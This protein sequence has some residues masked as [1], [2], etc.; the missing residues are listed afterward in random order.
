IWIHHVR[1]ASG[2]DRRPARAVWADQSRRSCPIC[3]V[4]PGGTITRLA[5]LLECARGKRTPTSRNDACEIGFRRKEEVA[6]S[7]ERVLLMS[8]PRG[9][10]CMSTLRRLSS[11]GLEGWY[12]LPCCDLFESFFDG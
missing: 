10:L 9:N 5:L 7:R 11:R 4:M 3:T 6:R 8:S 2:V 1:H 12:P